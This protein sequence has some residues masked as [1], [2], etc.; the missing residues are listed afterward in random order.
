MCYFDIKT[1][2]VANYDIAFKAAIEETK[3]LSEET[4]KLFLKEKDK[5]E[6]TKRNQSS[7]VKKHKLIVE[8][9]MEQEEEPGCSYHTGKCCARCNLN[10]LWFFVVV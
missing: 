5:L 3:S 2:H 1:G 7:T 9:S 4:Q 6:K 8:K 10:F